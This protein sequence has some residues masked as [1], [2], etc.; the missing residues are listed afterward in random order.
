MALHVRIF[1]ADMLNPSLKSR[2]MQELSKF[3]RIFAG[4]EGYKISPLENKKRSKNNKKRKFASMV[5]DLG[6]YKN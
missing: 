3:S 5:S 1:I 2:F 6:S 4:L